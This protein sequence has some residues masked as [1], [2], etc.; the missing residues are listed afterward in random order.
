[1][2][3]ARS[4][5]HTLSNCED[6]SGP[7][8]KQMSDLLDQ[9]EDDRLHQEAAKLRVLA[10]EYKTGR[11]QRKLMHVADHLDPYETVGD[12]LVRKSDGKPVEL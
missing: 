10:A 2:T 6:A 4:Q 8:C 5:I 7:E 9:V 11:V 12:Q 3:Y 1:M